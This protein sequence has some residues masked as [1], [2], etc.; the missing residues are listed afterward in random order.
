MMSEGPISKKLRAIESARELDAI[1]PPS[2]EMIKNRKEEQAMKHQLHML[3]HEAGVLENSQRLEV[4]A[5]V[6]CTD[7]ELLSQ[8]YLKLTDPEIGVYQGA[9]EAVELLRA[10]FKKP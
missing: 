6:G 7:A 5:Q 2:A 10:R 8:I 4:A 3:R 1:Y 9:A